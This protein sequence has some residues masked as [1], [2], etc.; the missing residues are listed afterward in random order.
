[1]DFLTRDHGFV[2]LGT[3]N[4][5]FGYFSTGFAGWG[6]YFSRANWCVRLR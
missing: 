2:S 6:F 1:M 4:T 5:A 3:V